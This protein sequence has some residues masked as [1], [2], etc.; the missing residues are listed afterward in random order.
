MAQTKEYFQEYYKKNKEK[1]NRQSKEWYENNPER[2]KELRKKRK[3]S[4]KKSQKEWVENNRDKVKAYRSEY[5]KRDIP[6]H[7]KNVRKIS[8]RRMPIEGAICEECGCAESLHRHHNDYNDPMDVTIL[9][10]KCHVEWHSN[11][12]PKEPKI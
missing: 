10:K 5:N 7:K 3:E 4:H 2:I 9:C 8:K 11:N 12:T 1:M 6:R